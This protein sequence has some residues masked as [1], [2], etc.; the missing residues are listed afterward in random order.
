MSNNER[1]T[2]T[3]G[4][5]GKNLRVLDVSETK[6]FKLFNG[7]ER[8]HHINTINE[9]LETYGLTIKVI[10]ITEEYVEYNIEVLK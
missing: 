3:L 7:L 6:K 2:E 5:L 10:D 4:N 9:V 1:V 8:A